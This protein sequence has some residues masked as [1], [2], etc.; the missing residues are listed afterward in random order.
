MQ[1]RARFSYMLGCRHLKGFNI[2]WHVWVCVCACVHACV[3]VC[4]DLVCVPEGQG[5][6]GGGPVHA[7]MSSRSVLLRYTL[8][9]QLELKWHHAQTSFTFHPTSPQPS[10]RVDMYLD[11][12]SCKCAFA[13]LEL[14]LLQGFSSTACRVPLLACE[15]IQG[16]SWSHQVLAQAL[17]SGER[18]ATV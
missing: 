4:V 12:H 3:R 6:R 14:W 1:W 13:K 10:L 16:R 7:L 18:A 17:G 15:R 11:W 8:P 9:L 5:E 2:C